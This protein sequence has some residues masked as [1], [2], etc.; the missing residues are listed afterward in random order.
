M[1][2][3][4]D[5]DLYRFF[6]HY[7]DHGDGEPEGQVSMNSVSHTLT[8]S[9]P[10][11]D[12]FPRMTDV[13]LIELA[14]DIKEHGQLDPIIVL[15]GKILDGRNREAA[16]RMAG[17]CPEYKEATADAAKD[18]LAY[19]LSRNLHRRQLARARR[20]R[21]IA[22]VLRQRPQQ[23]NRDVADQTGTDHKTVGAVREAM[24]AT[25]EIPQLPQTEG[26]D[27]KARPVRRKAKP[28]KNGT[29]ERE[30]DPDH[31]PEDRKVRG[32]GIE[33][34]AEAINALSRIPK[35]DPLRQAGIKQ[36]AGWIRTW[37]PDANKHIPTDHE[38]E[39]VY[40]TIL[41]LRRDVEAI[42]AGTKK[43]LK[44]WTPGRRRKFCDDL[45]ALGA[46]L[47]KQAML[48]RPH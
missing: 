35:N 46:W 12:L 4:L 1:T 40:Q 34:A 37:H 42:T 24:E 13:E 27:G 9:H 41:A 47:R 39:T 10:A 6:D 31:N 32:K 28:H 17:V 45:D 29:P 26:R 48:G 8:P 2:E 25:G 18:P 33:A 36:V 15:D 19:V 44:E 14:K 38:L 43:V 3:I 22:A 7:V 20:R 23:S 16:C 11:A 21:V 30:P 5:S